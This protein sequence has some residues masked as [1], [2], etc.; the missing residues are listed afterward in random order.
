MISCGVP[1][2][3]LSRVHIYDVIG[4]PEL[5][6]IINDCGEYNIS[7]AK[8]EV[9]FV[10]LEAIRAH[11]DAGAILLECTDLPPHAAAIQAATNLPVFDATSMV[12]FIHSLCEF[13][14]DSVIPVGE[15][16]YEADDNNYCRNVNEIRNIRESAGESSFSEN[17]GGTTNNKKPLQR[18]KYKAIVAL[19][20]AA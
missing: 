16:Q 7:K 4:Q 5:G 10:A 3:M 9:I 11:S 8:D 14:D 18:R 19:Q 17:R 2:D 15:N 13:S 1:E 12:K 6:K 20:N